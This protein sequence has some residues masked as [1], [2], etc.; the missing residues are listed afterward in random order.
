MLDPEDLRSEG[1]EE[2]VILWGTPLSPARE[3]D[4]GVLLAYERTSD[5][6]GRRY[7]LLGGARVLHVTEQEFQKLLRAGRR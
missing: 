3:Q 6:T 1:G 2:F 7:V 5:K 4:R